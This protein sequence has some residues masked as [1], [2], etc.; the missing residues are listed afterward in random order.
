[1]RHF[2]LVF[3]ILCAAAFAADVVTITIAGETGQIKWFNQILDHFNYEDTR[4]FQAR[5]VVY[6]QYWDRNPKSPLLFYTGNEGDVTMFAGNTGFM[7]T[8]AKKLNALVIFAEHRYYGESMPFGQQSFDLD[9]V[10]FL[11][12]EQALADYANLIT[13]LKNDPALVGLHP[14]APVIAFGGSYGGMLSAWFRL[15][16]PS[17]VAGSIAGSAPVNCFVGV[18]DSEAFSEVTTAD[19]PCSSDIHADFRAVAEYATSTHGRDIIQKSLNL[20]GALETADAVEGVLNY[21]V[22]AATY[23]AMTDYPYPADFLQP[24]PGYPANYTCTLGADYAKQRGQPQ[25]QTPHNSGELPWLHALLAVYYNSSGQAGTCFN[26]SGSVSPSLGMQAWDYQA[27]TELVLPTGSN[28][29]DDCL[30]AQPFNLTALEEYCAV[31]WNVV[32]DIGWGERW[33]AGEFMAGAASN[34]VFSNGNLDPWSPYGVLQV[35]PNGRVTAVMIEGGAHHLDLR[36]PNPADPPSV[37]KARALEEASILQWIEA[38][39]QSQ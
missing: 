27:C 24:M 39:N 29:I 28:G 1:M 17:I 7:F 33:G 3:A 35:P 16:Y 25:E 31:T 26:T 8:V 36:G 14:A 4:M 13:A 5:Y 32:P 38:W 2:L 21:A 30:P 9:K 34:I 12:V 11:S 37:L 6:D 18:A 19:F 23:M 10:G 22:A 15:K 20:C